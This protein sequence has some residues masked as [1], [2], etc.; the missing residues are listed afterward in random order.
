MIED[1]IRVLRLYEFIGPRSKVEAQIAKSVHG[2][3]DNGNGVRIVGVT[4]GEAGE[5]IKAA[6]EKMS[7]KLKDLLK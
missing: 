6:S 4:L 2:S 5:I 7:E 3:R 1:T